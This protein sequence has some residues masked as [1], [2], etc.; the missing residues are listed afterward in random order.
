MWGMKKL[1][2]LRILV[3]L[4]A[5]AGLEVQAAEISASPGF[6]RSQPTST[7][8]T[9]SLLAPSLPAAVSKTELSGMNGGE[10]PVKYSRFFSEHHSA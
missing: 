2:A 6:A 8:P 9:G 7:P 4:T 1:L 10:N 3:A 5:L